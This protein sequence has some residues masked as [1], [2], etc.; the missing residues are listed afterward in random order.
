MNFREYITEG[1]NDVFETSLLKLIGKKFKS[2]SIHRIGRYGNDWGFE[3]M[4]K[5]KN[6]KEAE[7]INHSDIIK[8][9]KKEYPGISKDKRPDSESDS[10]VDGK[11]IQSDNWR[12]EEPSDP[13]QVYLKFSADY[14]DIKGK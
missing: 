13:H 1:E 12:N 2:V 14:K 4:I 9:I 6:L 5:T 7:N 10:M 3:C 8:L 11:S